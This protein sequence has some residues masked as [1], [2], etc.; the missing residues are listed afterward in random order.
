M[1]RLKLLD[2]GLLEQSHLVSTIVPS[3]KS[4]EDDGSG[5][6]DAGAGARGGVNGGRIAADDAAEIMIRIDKFTETALRQAR[7]DKRSRDNYKDGLV[8]EER[9]KLLAE[10]ARK[11]A[12]WKKCTRCLA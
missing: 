1:A 5:D 12:E 11:S 4:R 9:K 3:A 6:E 7:A 2:A 8:Y 10:F